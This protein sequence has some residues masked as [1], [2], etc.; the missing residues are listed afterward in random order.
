ME[1]RVFLS[2]AEPGS[3]DSDV[4]LGLGLEVKTV[5]GG[6]V[7]TAETADGAAPAPKGYQFIEVE[8]VADGSLADQAGQLALPHNLPVFHMVLTC[9]STGFLSGVVAGDTLISIDG[10]DIRLASDP[11]PFKSVR[12]AMASVRERAESPVVEWCFL[13]HAESTP[14][15][16]RQKDVVLH[17]Q[18]KSATTLQAAWRG[19]QSRKD[20]FD[21]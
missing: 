15:E 5:G 6:T 8:S 13:R 20:H 11:D 14:E 4:E 10:T 12:R 16:I 9:R 21:L 18:H 7:E 2:L 17:H 19:I 3:D 1:H